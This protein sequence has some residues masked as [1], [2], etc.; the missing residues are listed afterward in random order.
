MSEKKEQYE[1]IKKFRKSLLEHERNLLDR[2]ELRNITH[3][4]SSAIWL[5]TDLSQPKDGQTVVYR[6]MGDLEVAFIL[7]NGILPDTQPYQAIIEGSDG[8]TYSEKYLIGKK[9]TDTN[10]STV[11]EFVTSIELIAVLMKKQCKVE[12]GAISMGL[13]IAAGK[14]LPLFNQSIQNGETTWRIVKVK[15]WKPK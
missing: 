11:M 3:H 5:E 9:R 13:G 8:F 2:G 7:K 6:P 1:D 15:R 14:G 10:P 4:G 12:D